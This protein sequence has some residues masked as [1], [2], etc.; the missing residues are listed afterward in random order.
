MHWDNKV[1]G[2]NLSGNTSNTFELFDSRE[3]I[4][5]RF[6]LSLTDINQINHVITKGRTKIRF[7]AKLGEITSF[8]VFS[9]A[10]ERKIIR[11]SVER[12]PF[13]LLASSQIS[14]NSG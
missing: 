3:T 12:N 9:L 4:S 8:E 14:K 6:F 10:G 13:S 1:T 7:L 11:S 5:N 2:F